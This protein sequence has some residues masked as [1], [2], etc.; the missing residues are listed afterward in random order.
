MPIGPPLIHTVAF[1]PATH[2]FSS[3]QKEKGKVVTL[4]GYLGARADLSKKLSFVQLLSKDLRHSLQ[5]KSGS[6]DG[7]GQ[8]N[9]CHGE[10]KNLRAHTPV[11]VRG[12]LVERPG[13][14]RPGVKDVSKIVNVELELQEVYPLNDFPEDVIMKEDTRFPPEQRH[15]QIRNEKSLRDALV[16]RDQAASICR[17]QLSAE[18]FVEIETPQ[19]FKS[20]PEG[21]REFLVPTRERGLVYALP[22]SPQQYKQILMGS[23]IPKYYQMARC[24]RDE[25]LRADRQPEFTQVSYSPC[26]S[27]P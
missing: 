17:T 6:Q 1:P 23:G 12:M 15:L 13:S 7:R 27:L 24:F 3:L 20:T 19:L 26:F 18:K 21:A 14:S 9:P 22:Q 16:F 25:D 5:I 4:H 10:I 11:A 8:S 2:T